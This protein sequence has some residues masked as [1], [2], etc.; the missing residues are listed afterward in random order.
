MTDFQAE[1]IIRGRDIDPPTETLTASFA[2]RG[3]WKRQR[4]LA[5]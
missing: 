4:S 5:D 1:T 2:E 3:A